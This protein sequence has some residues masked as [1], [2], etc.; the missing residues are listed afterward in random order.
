MCYS[1]FG[2]NLSKNFKEILMMQLPH[3]SPVPRRAIEHA[4]PQRRRGELPGI[5]M[6]GVIRLWTYMYMYIS[7]MDIWIY[8]F[9]WI[10][11]DIWIYGYMDSYGY[12][13]SYGNI[14]DSW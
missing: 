4:Q 8:G 9:I 12:M 7:Y 3:W 5:V 1:F 14:D 6:A 10:H 11:M 2:L 13:G